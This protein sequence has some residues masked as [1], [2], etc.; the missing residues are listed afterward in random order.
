M[1]SKTGEP[2]TLAC[3]FDCQK[4]EEP[5]VISAQRFSSIIK[6]SKTLNDDLYKTLSHAD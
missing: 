1:A 2:S 6:A 4:K 5:K 3:I